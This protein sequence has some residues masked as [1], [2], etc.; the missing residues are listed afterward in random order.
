MNLQLKVKWCE[1]LRSGEH[2]QAHG[3]MFKDDR[4]CCLGVLAI[5]VGFSREQSG[6]AYEFIDTQIGRSGAERCIHRN[7]G[8]GMKKHTFEEIAD[9][10]ESEL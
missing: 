8:I 1:A 5:V 6:D 3:M 9:F 7:D 2:K 10:I 4:S